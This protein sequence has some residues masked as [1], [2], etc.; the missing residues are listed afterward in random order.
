MEFCK[1]AGGGT[2][3]AAYPAPPTN[4]P[5]FPLCQGSPSDRCKCSK[6]EHMAYVTGQLTDSGVT[7]ASEPIWAGKK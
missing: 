4:N 7:L 5:Y 3:D 1:A 2:R 6:D